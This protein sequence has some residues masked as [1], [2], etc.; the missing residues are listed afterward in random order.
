[1]YNNDPANQVS[2]TQSSNAN[3]TVASQSV[4]SL[5][6]RSSATC[7]IQQQQQQ[8]PDSQ[9]YSNYLGSLKDRIGERTCQ[10]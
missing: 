7:T 5:T 2:R 1:M 8:Q 9:A 10:L 6:T 4:L 3:I